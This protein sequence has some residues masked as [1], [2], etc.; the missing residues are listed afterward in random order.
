MLLK[1]ITVVLCF[2]QRCS[3]GFQNHRQRPLPWSHFKEN[4]WLE[5]RYCDICTT[6]F[7]LDYCGCCACYLWTWRICFERQ[8]TLTCLIVVTC[9][10]HVL[11]FCCTLKLYFDRIKEKAEKKYLI[12]DWCKWWNSPS[13]KAYGHSASKEILVLW[14]PEDYFRVHKIPPPIPVPSQLK[15]IS[16]LTRNL[17]LVRFN[18]IVNIILNAWCRSSSLFLLG[19]WTSIL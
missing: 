13:W 15:P 19:F 16:I 11:G 17:F 3:T 5:C 1:C 4:Y 18:I 8:C 7:G 12:K 14:K 6:S 10:A 9:G 2:T